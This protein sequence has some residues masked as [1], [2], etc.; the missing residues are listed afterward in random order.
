MYLA[1]LGRQPEISMAELERVFGSSSV[2]RYSDISALVDTHDFDIEKLGGIL[3]AGLVLEKIPSSDWQLIERHLLKTIKP[4][5][6]SG[7]ITIGLSVYGQKTPP[8]TIKKTS[9][10]I[11]NLIKSQGY[12]VR[13]ISPENNSLSTASS[14]HNKLGLSPNKIEIIVV[15]NNS[16]NTIICSSVGSQNISSYAQRDQ[17]R[18]KRDPFVGML[19]P[20]LAQIMVNLAAGQNENIRILDPFCGTGVILQ[21]SALLGHKPYGTDI[22]DKMIDYSRINLEW[23][24]KTKHINIEPVLETA[25]ATSY[26]WTSSFNAV[27]TESYLGQPFSAPPKTEKLNQVVGN[28]NHII[29]NFLKNIGSQVKTG[30]NLCVAV[31]AWRDSTGKITHLPL[32]KNLRRLG[33]DRIKLSTCDNTKLI[34]YRENQVV[35]RE[36]LLL[37]KT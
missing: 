16:R 34:Y 15:T 33:Y 29:E 2:S 6:E 37:S 22:S 28:C 19:P 7:K 8:S 23:L 20:K 31:P 13:L 11:K 18:P 36:L 35:A 12:S 27:A 25:D 30:T 3:K 21:E 4:S 9:L 26:R 5:V 14:H 24:S 32:L 17:T 1:L 10:K